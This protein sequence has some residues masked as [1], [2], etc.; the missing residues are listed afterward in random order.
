MAV[1]EEEMEEILRSGLMR[2]HSMVCI[3]SSFDK[4]C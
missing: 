4:L 1:G 3:G 2:K